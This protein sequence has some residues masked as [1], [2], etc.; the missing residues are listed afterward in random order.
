MRLGFIGLGQMG[1][2]IAHN[3]L[4]SGAD[5]IIS[6]RTDRWFGE[7]RDKGVTRHNQPRRSRRH[8]YPLPVPAQ[9]GGACS[10][11]SWARAA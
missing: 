1:R 4:N 11:S 10:R 2:P 8:G 3:L 5:L 7:F 6:S 9:H